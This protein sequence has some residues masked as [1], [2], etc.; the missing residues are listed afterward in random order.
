MKRK[1]LLIVVLLLVLF[2]LDK[3][4]KNKS[5][6]YEVCQCTEKGDVCIKYEK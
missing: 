4:H 1:I 2:S 3:I 5:N 6:Y